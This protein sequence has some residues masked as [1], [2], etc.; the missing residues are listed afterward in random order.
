MPIHVEKTTGAFVYGSPFLGRIDHTAQ[1]D[2]D[3]SGFTEDE[4]DSR[5]YLKPGVPLTKDGALV[6]VAG[7]L[8]G[9]T[10]EPLKVVEGRVTGFAQAG[11]DELGV[12]TVAVAT[13]GQV[14]LDAA[15]DILGRAYTED[16]IAGF[17]ASNITLL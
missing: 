12:I 16:E 15:E 3:L 2:V 9:V 8:F 4:I 7:L 5:G 14:V 11:I 17:E 6:G 13:H 1:I 10:I